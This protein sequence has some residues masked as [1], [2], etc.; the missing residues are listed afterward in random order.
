MWGEPLDDTWSIG[1]KIYSIEGKG[2]F[3]KRC[4]ESRGDTTTTSIEDFYNR[5]A[6]MKASGRI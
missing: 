3:C 5:I 2:Y 4:Y 1:L 6:E